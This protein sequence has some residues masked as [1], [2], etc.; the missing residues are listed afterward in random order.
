MKTHRQRCH[1]ELTRDVIFLF[2]EN[3]GRR[4]RHI[5]DSNWRTVG[6]WLDRDE[7]EQWGGSQ[8]HNYGE[9]H[10]GWR[11]YGIPS[12]GKLAEMLRMA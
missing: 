4:V 2:Q 9:K 7:A 3:T 5:P 8:R 11:V 10:I 1:D 12:E 6:V